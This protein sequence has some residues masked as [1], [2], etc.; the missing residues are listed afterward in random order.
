[1][2][3]DAF[4]KVFTDTGDPFCW[5]LSR[6][7]GNCG[8]GGSIAEAPAAEAGTGNSYNGADTRFPERKD[9]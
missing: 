4:W 1:M 2:K 9:L 6:A 8:G 5:L 7:H 3:N